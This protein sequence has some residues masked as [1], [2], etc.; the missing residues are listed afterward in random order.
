MIIVNS[1]NNTVFFGINKVTFL[2]VGPKLRDML[3]LIIILFQ[4]VVISVSFVRYLIII[5]TYFSDSETI[6]SVF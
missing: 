3:L 2:W 4:V 5:Y 6:S 1:N